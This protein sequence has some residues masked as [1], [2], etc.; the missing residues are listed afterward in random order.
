MPEAMTPTFP[1]GW[2]QY[3][4]AQA[5][6]L[7]ESRVGAGLDAFGAD[8]VPVIGRQS[9]AEGPP[10]AAIRLDRGSLVS[11]RND[12]LDALRPIVTNLH[13]DLLFSTFGAYELA[14]VTQPDGLGIWGPTLYFFGDASTWSDPGDPRVVQLSSDDLAAVDR[15]RFW[16]CYVDQARDG[17]GVIE[18][19][20]LVALA[21][22]CHHSDGIEEIGM[23]VMPEAQGRGVGRAIVG[24]A[25]MAILER[26][27]LVLATTASFNVPSA[28]TLRSVGLRYAYSEMFAFGAF[29]GA[30]PVPPQALGHPY[31][32]A[33]LANY[34]PDFAMNQDIEPRP[35]M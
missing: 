26:R 28:R 10:L 19:G 18:D 12:W 35:D 27:N 29:G 32:G 31:P 20:D 3:L 2:R 1:D 4:P 11:A 23:D 33:R 21:A 17:Y 8:P 14:R 5:V 30:F 24:A 25:G 6:A 7:I 13:Q 9:G 16:H 34:Y 15:A 22:V